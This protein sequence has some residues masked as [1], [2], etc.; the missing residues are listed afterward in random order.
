MYYYIIGLNVF[1]EP[2]MVDM[3]KLISIKHTIDVY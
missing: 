1:K 2:N 3:V